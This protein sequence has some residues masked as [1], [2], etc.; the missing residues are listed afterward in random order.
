MTKQSGR[1]LNYCLSRE[2]QNHSKVKKGLK[3]TV[4]KASRAK[5]RKNTSK[6]TKELY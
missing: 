5:L 6:E 1:G 4:T 2:G 3:R